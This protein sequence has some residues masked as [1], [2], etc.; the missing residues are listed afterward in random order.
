ML[1]QELSERDFFLDATSRTFQNGTFKML[2]AIFWM[3]LNELSQT[4]SFFKMLSH[5]WSIWGV[6][7][8]FPADLCSY[9]VDLISNGEVN[10]PGGPE[11]PPTLL[12]EGHDNGPHVLIVIVINIGDSHSVLGVCPKCVCSK[13]SSSV[14]TIMFTAGQVGLYGYTLDLWLQRAILWALWHT[15]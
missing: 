4:H 3:L 1:L 9:I 5:P 15:A 2:K 7:E 6:S 10:S 11:S 12:H 14:I 13:G 8:K